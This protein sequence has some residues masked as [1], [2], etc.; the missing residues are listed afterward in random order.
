MLACW[1]SDW[2]NLVARQEIYQRI[3][4]DAVFVE[5]WICEVVISQQVT[6]GTVELR[7]WKNLFSFRLQDLH[8]CG[9]PLHN[10]SNGNIQ[11]PYQVR[12]GDEVMSCKEHLVCSVFCSFFQLVFPPSSGVGQKGI[13]M[14]WSW[15]C[16]VQVWKTYSTF[17]TE[18]SASKQFCCLQI[19][20]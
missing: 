6:F 12:D 18:S 17:A 13:T 16:W 19:K 14:C 7:R 10:A 4:S 15:T 20:P 1:A 9:T 11:Y 5:P 8:Q 3:L 2:W